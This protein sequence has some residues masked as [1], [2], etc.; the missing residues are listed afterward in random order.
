MPF[1]LGVFL[2]YRAAGGKHAG[3]V[4]VI[5]DR[6][7]YRYQ[8]FLSDLAGHDIEAHSDNPHTAIGIVRNWLSHHGKKALPGR[9]QILDRY[10]SFTDEL[11]AVLDGLKRTPGDL[12]NFPD[13]L[14]AVRTWL[15]L[16]D[17]K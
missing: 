10:V 17:G 16:K 9:E 11:P 15:G 12:N 4:A 2:G 13:Y 7:K 14:T 6:E 3:K 8:Q 5:L 1:E